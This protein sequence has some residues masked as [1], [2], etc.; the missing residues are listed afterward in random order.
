MTKEMDVSCNIIE[1]WSDLILVDMEAEY[2][3]IYSSRKRPDARASTTTPSAAPA[4]EAAA[5]LPSSPAT[6]KTV[7][8]I[9]LVPF[10]KNQLSREVDELRSHNLLPVLLSPQIKHLKD[11]NLIRNKR[12]KKYN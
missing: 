11:K 5:L 2:Q 8:N 9:V 6:H 3:K 10:T 4:V 12:K 1:N 7:K